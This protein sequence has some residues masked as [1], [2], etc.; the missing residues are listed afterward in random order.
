MNHENFNKT[1][2][3]KH[4]N[5]LKKIKPLERANWSSKD[6]EFGSTI[7]MQSYSLTEIRLSNLRNPLSILK[8]QTFSSHSQQKLLIKTVKIF[9]LLQKF[10]APVNSETKS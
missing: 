3:I 5:H 4:Q 10:I 1:G 2:C 8:R 7:E 9:Q 6:K